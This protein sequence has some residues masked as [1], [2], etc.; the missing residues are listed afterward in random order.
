MNVNYTGRIG[1]TDGSVTKVNGSQDAEELQKALDVARQFEEFFVRMMVQSFRKAQLSDEGGMFG[2]SV[3]SSTY[4]QWF[5]QHMSEH[6][7][8][9]SGIGIADTLIRDFQRLG[10]LPKA[11]HGTKTT[12]AKGVNHV[13]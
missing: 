2:N 6:L 3:G 7:A 5:D 9:N 8:K 4:E 13:A 12:Q 11:E 10:V 1:T